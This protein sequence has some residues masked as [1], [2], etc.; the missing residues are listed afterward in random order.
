MM[1]LYGNHLAACA[2]GTAFGKQHDYIS[3][4]IL[5]HFTVPLQR[6]SFDNSE[7]KYFS[8]LGIWK[9]ST[10]DNIGGTSLYLR[11]HSHS[12]CRTDSTTPSSNVHSL[13]TPSCSYIG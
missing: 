11:W 9:L 12:K 6:G 8:C 13:Y 10:T 5:E 4:C 7:A 2:T 3:T 1:C